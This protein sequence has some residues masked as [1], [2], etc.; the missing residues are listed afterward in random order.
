M[1]NGKES[2]P[3]DFLT[4]TAS[5]LM[6]ITK[7]FNQVI[8]EDNLHGHWMLGFFRPNCKGQYQA[9]ETYVQVVRP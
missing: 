2:D 7:G 4:R 8:L 5:Y 9:T 1:K 3:T 6:L